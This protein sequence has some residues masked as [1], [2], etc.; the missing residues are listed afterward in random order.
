RRR[1][2][3]LV[4]LR[5]LFPENRLQ[6][7]EASARVREFALAN[8]RQRLGEG[9]ELLVLRQVAPGDR[10]RLQDLLPA[11]EL[12]QGTDQGGQA[13]FVRAVVA[14]LV[15]LGVTRRGQEGPRSLQRG[16]RQAELL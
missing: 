10:A 12:D 5:R 1:R 11:L 15:P 3:S 14:I 7:A 8:V 13:L 6:L 9:A 2:L 16:L 4:V